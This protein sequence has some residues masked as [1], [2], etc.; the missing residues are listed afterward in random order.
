MSDAAVLYIYKTQAG[1]EVKLL[2]ES[3]AYTTAQVRDHFAGTYPELTNASSSTDDKAQTVEY[4][5]RQVDV[6]KIV[7]FAKR[8]G[9]KGG[10]IEYFTFRVEGMVRLKAG[11]DQAGNLYL[12]VVNVCDEV[13]SLN[14]DHAAD[15]VL[16]RTIETYASRCDGDAGWKI[17][18]TV[19][20]L[21]E[22][23]LMARQGWPM[24]P[25]FDR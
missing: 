18:P 6:G 11:R 7:T 1:R 24:L 12:D 4:E 2:D 13:Q 23:E 3:G 10:D 16:A 17:R 15:E 22:T 8:V 21:A 5:G 9:T 14:S 25:G 19:T 20:L